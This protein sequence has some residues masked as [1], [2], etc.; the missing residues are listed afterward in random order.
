MCVYVSLRHINILVN[1]LL[2][3]FEALFFFLALLEPQSSV[4]SAPSILFL[5]PHNSPCW[6]TS[7]DGISKGQIQCILCN[8]ANENHSQGHNKCAWSPEKPWLTHTRTT[9]ILVIMI[10]IQYHSDSLQNCVEYL[11]NGKMFTSQICKSPTE[12]L[13][14]GC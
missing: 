4:V 3:A 11:Q 5:F 2:N 14:L 12:T 6:T 10:G 1:I 9:Q 7:H 8:V 13:G